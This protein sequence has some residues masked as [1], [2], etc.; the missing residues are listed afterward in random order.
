MADST[1]FIDTTSTFDATSYVYV[2][3]STSAITAAAAAQA[4]SLV[5]DFN[6]A[7]GPV[8]KRAKEAESQFNGIID[9]LSSIDPT[10]Y[11]PEAMMDA[12]TQ[13]ALN[14]S[15]AST[16]W[17]QGVD[18]LKQANVVSANCSL[19]DSG[20]VPKYGDLA[21]Q[22]NSMRS[23]V[24][25]N[26]TN[27]ISKVAT[28][29]QAAAGRTIAELEIGKKLS[30][31]VNTGSSESDIVNKSNSSPVSSI[32]ET[33]KAGIAKSQS[34]MGKLAGPMKAL[35]KIMDCTNALGGAEYSGDVDNMID[36]TQNLYQKMYM[37]DDPASPQYG[38]FNQG[39]FANSIPTVPKK[40]LDNTFKVANMF[41]KSDNN[42]ALST[43]RLVKQAKEGAK[44]TS[45][46]APNGENQTNDDKRTIAD[47]VSEFKISFPKIPAAPG[48]AAQPGGSAT[49]PKPTPVVPPVVDTLPPPI[50]EKISYRN[51]IAREPEFIQNGGYISMDPQLSGVPAI[52][53]TATDLIPDGGTSD[54]SSQM[55]ITVYALNITYQKEVSKDGTQ[56]FLKIIGDVAVQYERIDK[57]PSGGYPIAQGNF[58]VR[59]GVVDAE[60]YKEKTSEQL[61]DYA[62]K[63][64][65]K[66]LT[67]L[68]ERGDLPKSKF[69]SAFQ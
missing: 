60:D 50:E 26:A 15:F 19:F 53:A 17:Q 69:D 18:A 6:S 8:E 2:D 40:V 48:R 38:E 22:V 23:G 35:D 42:A 4:S 56:A 3:D 12:F 16:S 21:R 14:E 62:P 61:R 41:N 10:D 59:A 49:S 7:V 27:A 58:N 32:L 44:S 28:D 25:E 9:T 47:Q 67:R 11:T 68:S 46:L 54:P 36:Q 29:I 5:N 33:G 64:V 65:R 55:K 39:A 45:S 31:L 43:D 13:N 52:L 51:L 57:T 34:L 30:S 37:F 66:A 24:L 1:A 63:F 20:S